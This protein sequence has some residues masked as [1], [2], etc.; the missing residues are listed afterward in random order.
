[1]LALSLRHH[2]IN[3]A[4]SRPDPSFGDGADPRTIAQQGLTD[5]SL[6]R[7]TEGT[8]GGVPQFTCKR[9]DSCMDFGSG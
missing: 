6:E 8:F 7:R 9:T 5:M 3:L 1:V 2:S 4:S